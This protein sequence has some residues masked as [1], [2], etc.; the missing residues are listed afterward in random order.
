MTERE[1][2]LLE[3]FKNLDRHEQNVIIGKASE[4]ALNNKKEKIHFFD[5]V[6]VIYPI[7]F[8]FIL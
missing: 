4:L 5:D 1:K 8:V 3:M 2:R 7:V 6:K